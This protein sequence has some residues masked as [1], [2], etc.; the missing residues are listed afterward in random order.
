MTRSNIIAAVAVCAALL[1]AGILIGTWVARP[2]ASNPMPVQLTI[3]P[4]RQA[5]MNAR[6]DERVEQL[7]LKNLDS[8]REMA[9]VDGRELTKAEVMADFKWSEEQYDRYDAMLSKLSEREIED[10]KN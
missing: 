4:E 7:S 9:A 5:A 8:L 3:S 6:I 10:L 1:L 2:T